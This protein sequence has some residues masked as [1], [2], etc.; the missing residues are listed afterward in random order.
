MANKKEFKGGVKMGKVKIKEL[1]EIKEELNTV[2]WK[3]AG[4]AMGSKM[5][6][7]EEQELNEVLA[8]FGIAMTG[9]ARFIEKA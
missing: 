8:V 4:L 5:S 7:D 2:I 6:K 1:I 3:I 9:L